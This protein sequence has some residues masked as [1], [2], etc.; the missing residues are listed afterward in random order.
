MI[1]AGSAVTIQVVAALTVALVAI[2]A[3]A[4]AFGADRAIRH[5]LQTLEIA[6]AIPMGWLPKR[7][8]K[9]GIRRHYKG[10]H[11]R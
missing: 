1:D 5:P 11:K 2:L 10:R 7:K 9:P 8:R 4:Y 3:M 6:I